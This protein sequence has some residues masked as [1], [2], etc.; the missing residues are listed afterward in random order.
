MSKEAQK[1]NDL[2]PITEI[3]LQKY[4]LLMQEQTCSFSFSVGMTVE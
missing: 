1:V 2:W 4:R 3:L